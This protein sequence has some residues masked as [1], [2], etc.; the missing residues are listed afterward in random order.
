LA[1]VPWKL[2]AYVVRGSGT[3]RIGAKRSN[4][5]P[6][7][8]A[9]T[10]TDHLAE[11]V[12]T[13]CNRLKKT[14]AA[15]WTDGVLGVVDR[16]V[17]PRKEG[18]DVVVGHILCPPNYLAGVVNARCPGVADIPPRVNA[19]RIEIIRRWIDRTVGSR[20]EGIYES[21]RRGIWSGISNH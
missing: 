15:V 20:T 7:G 13:V 21:I 11:V 3:V 14:A 2:R 12:G 17:R 16:T 4:P 5:S 19:D 9:I 6:S 18:M 1:G 8:A 10:P